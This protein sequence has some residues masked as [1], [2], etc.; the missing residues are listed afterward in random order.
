MLSPD[1]IGGAVGGF[2]T[3]GGA[4]LGFMR[5]MIRGAL[6]DHELHLDEKY[7]KRYV[8]LPQRGER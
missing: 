6:M 8:L 7:D 3:G 4:M 5:W 1:L 2:I